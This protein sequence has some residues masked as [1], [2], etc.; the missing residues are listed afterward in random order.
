LQG[1]LVQNEDKI[2]A[3][4]RFYN[5]GVG[6]LNIKMK[7]FPDNPLSKSLGFTEREFFEDED[8]ASVRQPPRVQ[9]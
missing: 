3:S 8:A 7:Q 1:E 5:G 2:S 4:R 6:V 9:F